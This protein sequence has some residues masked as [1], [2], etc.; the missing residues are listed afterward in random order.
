[1]L[2]LVGEREPA[3]AAA[4]DLARLDYAVFDPVVNETD[5][6]PK[7]IG[8]LPHGELFRSL[9]ARSG[10]RVAIA[11]P[12][13]HCEREGLPVRAAQP[14]FIQGSNDLWIA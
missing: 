12:L 3:G 6:H 14:L 5:A 1:M 4:V 8:Q 11:D 13:D 9:Q 10:H 7:L 2:L